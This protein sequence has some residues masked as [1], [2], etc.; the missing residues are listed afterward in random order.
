MVLEPSPFG[1]SATM[2]GRCGNASTSRR[3]Q[4]EGRLGKE[5]MHP[6]SNNA[7]ASFTSIFSL[8]PG[9]LLLL[10]G[11]RGSG[12]TIWCQNLYQ[13]AL[14][15]E[16]RV[17]GVI[18]PAVMKDGRKW[19][20]RV[21]ILP[22]TEQRE[23]AWS[24][25]EKD[26][27]SWSKNWCFDESSLAWANEH[28]ARLE[29]VELLIID[30]LGPL[31]FEMG[32]GLQHAFPLLDERNYRLAVVVVRPSLLSQAQARWPWAQI[33]SLAENIADD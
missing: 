5:T 22:G 17:G 32:R 1:P 20:M 13:R 2:Q 26:P 28:L 21:Q 9:T 12:K 29:D 25:S 6:T 10:T 14:E 24:R 8:P 33:I 19:G 31:E 4:P 27:P 23:F 18:S 11:P 7:L 15:K 30:E 3:L 16:L